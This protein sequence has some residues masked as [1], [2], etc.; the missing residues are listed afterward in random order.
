MVGAYVEK[1]TSWVAK[2]SQDADIISTFRK[3]IFPYLA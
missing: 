3:K 1:Y 2:I